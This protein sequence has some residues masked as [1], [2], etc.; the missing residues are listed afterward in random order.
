MLPR[1]ALSILTAT[2]LA[3]GGTAATAASV[4]PGN[5][6]P[7]R[8]GD[9]DLTTDAGLAKLKGRIHRAARKACGS[10]DIRDLERTAAANA[11]RDFALS[12]ANPEIELAV[13]AAKR[14]EGYAST[15]AISVHSR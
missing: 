2:T 1:I 10:Y 5:S 13:A 12:K 11:C 15:G 8:F 6:V 9:L 4:E 7:V 3:L 14:G